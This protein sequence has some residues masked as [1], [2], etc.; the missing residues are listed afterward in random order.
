[1]RFPRVPHLRGQ[2]G[3]VL[4]IQSYSLLNGYAANWLVHPLSFLGMFSFSG[5]PIGSVALLAFFISIAGNLEAAV[6]LYDV[7]FCL[8]AVFCS[9]SL[10]RYVFEDKSTQLVGVIFYLF[11]PIVYEFTYDMATSRAF[12]LAIMPLFLKYLLE[13]N[14]GKG[15]RHLVA[16]IILFG[17]MN[18]FH[19]SAFAL[20]SSI[21]LAILFRIIQQQ[22]VRF[23]WREGEAKLLNRFLA[24]IFV[25]LIIALFTSSALLYG[26]EPKNTLPDQILPMLSDPFARDLVGL[27]ID[28]LLFMGPGLVLALLGIYSILGPIWNSSDLLFRESPKW[29]LLLFFATPLVPFIGNPAYTRHLFAPLIACYATK[30]I[31]ALKEVTKLRFALVLLATI[32]PFVAFFQLYNIFWMEV[33]PYASLSTVILIMLCVSWL[34]LGPLL[35]RIHGRGGYVFGYRR[36]Y[37]LPEVHRHRIREW[38]AVVLLTVLFVVTLTNIDMRT[39]TD[40][41]GRLISSYTTD[42]EVAIASYIQSQKMLYSDQTIILC[43]HYVLELRIAAYAETNALSEGLG[44]GI[45]EVGYV[46]QNDALQNST[47]GSFLDILTPH[48]YSHPVIS[49]DLWFAIMYNNYSEPSVQELLAELNIRYFIGLKGTNESYYRVRGPFESLF[50]MTLTAPIV[51]E[52]ANFLVYKLDN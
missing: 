42:E 16:A 5:Y 17:V 50:R 28:Y 21:V 51:Y 26:V 25:G 31:Q 24:L 7:F 22:L 4:I 15:H 20:L 3:F 6:L 52:T 38:S 40:L 18:L 1:M 30:G 10:M 32:V 41:E 47:T 37:V 11:L 44:T 33:E 13:W 19:R 29:A 35:T 8:I 46:T 23:D 34:L 2:D 14:D 45:M 36:R 27:A 12:F 39:V 49:K 9:A 48:I 43:S